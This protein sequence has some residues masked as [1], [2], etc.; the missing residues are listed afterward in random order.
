MNEAGPL[1]SVVIPT[2]Q[3]APFIEECLAGVSAQRFPGPVEILIGDDGSTDGTAEICRKF[4]VA[5]AR[6]KLF[7]RDPKDKIYINGRPTG[8]KNVRQL[9]QD[10]RGKYVAV[11]EGDDLWT[12]PFK[13]QHQL[14]SLEDDPSCALIFHRANTLRDGKLELHPLPEGLDLD[15]IRFDDLLRTYNFITTASIFFR[16]D[17]GEFPSWYDHVPFADLALIFL[18]SQQGGIRC[19]D[20]VMSVYRITAHGSWSKLSWEQRY[21]SYLKFYEVIYPHLT[22]SQQQIVQRKWKVTLDDMARNRSRFG[23]LRVAYRLMLGLQH[24]L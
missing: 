23:P 9:F 16:N 8:R 19:I 22:P 3:H 15:N 5:D 2:F 13:L 20:E 11:C 7:I 1:I 18:C 10:A 14:R 4:A 24:Q 17:L 21:Q 12:D 6:V